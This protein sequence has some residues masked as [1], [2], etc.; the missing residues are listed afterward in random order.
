MSLWLFLLFYAFVFLLGFAA[1]G[2]FDTW[3][4]C[5]PHMQKRMRVFAQ[6][7]LDDPDPVGVTD[8]LPPATLDQLALSPRA[9]DDWLASLVEQGPVEDDD[10]LPQPN[11][12]A[13]P[14][15]EDLDAPPPSTSR[16][17]R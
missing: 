3:M 11:S 15:L 5:K 7:V 1:R 10:E 13:A 2:R 4:N 17:A 16:F 12:E 6:Q 9:T 14:T 8:Y